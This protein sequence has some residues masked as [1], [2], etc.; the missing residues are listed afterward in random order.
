MNHFLTISSPLVIYRLTIRGNRLNTPDYAL[1]L[2]VGWFPSPLEP[3]SKLRNDAD[4]PSNQFIGILCAGAGTWGCQTM[5][6]GCML[7]S[8]Q[9]GVIKAVLSNVSPDMIRRS[10]KYVQGPR[11][12][13]MNR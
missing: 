2:A 6:A 8:V 11:S 10:L 4:P 3:R 9:D 12:L 1:L 7:V 13:E 5:E